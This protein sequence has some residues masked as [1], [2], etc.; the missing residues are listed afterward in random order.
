M[1]NEIKVEGADVV[2]EEN[3]EI[4]QLNNKYPNYLL[5]VWLTLKNSFKFNIP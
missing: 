5:Q 1:M 3:L 4:S 2:Q